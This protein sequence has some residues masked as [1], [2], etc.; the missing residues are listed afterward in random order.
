MKAHEPPHQIQKVRL[1]FEIERESEAVWFQNEMSRLFHAHLSKAIE[2]VLDEFDVPGYVIRLDSLDLDLGVVAVDH[3]DH[4]LPKLLEDALR[5]ALRD[6]LGTPTRKPP[7]VASTQAQVLP[8]ASAKI[9][10]LR[11]F[12][13]T[14]NA[15]TGYKVQHKSMEE[16][17]Q[18]VAEEAADEVKSMLLEAFGQNPIVLTRIANQFHGRSFE[19]IYKMFV[20]AYQAFLISQEKETVALLVRHENQGLTFVQREVR[21][22][23]LGY[24]LNLGT[25]QFEMPGF[26]EALRSQMETALGPGTRAAL[27]SEESSDPLESSSGRRL[28]ASVKALQN[29]LRSKSNPTGKSELLAAWEKL[30]LEDPKRLAAII[31]ANQGS[32][33]Q[34]Q[35]LMELLPDVSTADFLVRV[36]PS[37]AP[38]LSLVLAEVVSIF[39]AY[40]APKSGIQ[41]VRSLTLAQLVMYA[42]EVSTK[43]QSFSV[44]E[45][46]KR[47]GQ[48]VV[49]RPDIPEPLKKALQTNELPSLAEVVRMDPTQSMQPAKQ[50]ERETVTETAPETIQSRFEPAGAQDLDLMELELQD[51]EIKRRSEEKSRL[52]QQDFQ[53]KSEEEASLEKLQ[54][55]VQRQSDDAQKPKISEE[56]SAGA[57]KLKEK[58]LPPPT[59]ETIGGEEKAAT[60][61]GLEEVE[62]PQQKISRPTEVPVS[63][64]DEVAHY[65]ETISGRVAYLTHY[66]KHGTE[67]WWAGSPD[68]SRV[69]LYFSALLAVGFEPLKEAFVRLA[70]SSLPAQLD[71]AVAR[72]HRLVGK[73]LIV[74]FISKLL[75]DAGGLSAL[76]SE[77]M[78]GF[79]DTHGNELSL[80]VYISHPKDLRLHHSLK[81]ALEYQNS[82]PS[83]QTMVRYVLK[84]FS[85][86]TGKSVFD[87]GRDMV[88]WL[89]ERIGK[90]DRRYIVL[91]TILSTSALDLKIPEPVQLQPAP[92]EI[93]FRIWDRGGE[94]NAIAKEAAETSKET[95]TI[96]DREIDSQ[97]SKDTPP[98][99]LIAPGGKDE[100]EASEPMDEAAERGSE[101]DES[102]TSPLPE[103]LLWLESPS[104]GVKVLKYFL[105]TGAIPGDYP[106]PVTKPQLEE[107]IGYLLEAE[108]ASLAAMLKKVMSDR[109]IRLRFWRELPAWY[110][111]ILLVLMPEMGVALLPFVQ[112]MAEL[113]AFTSSPV[114]KSMVMEHALAY[115]L[116]VKAAIFSPL[117]YI[118]SLV[119]YA[120]KQGSLDARAVV[121]YFETR[122]EQ[123]NLPTKF[124]L[125][126][127]FRTIRSTYTPPRVADSGA[128]T[129]KPAPFR[130]LQDEYFVSNAGVVLLWPFFGQLFGFMKLLKPDK[131]EFVDELSQAK[132]AHVIQY[133]FSQEINV[134]EENMVLNKV[135]VGMSP[136]DQLMEIDPLTQ[137]EM[138]LVAELLGVAAE[139]SG[140]VKGPHGDALRET[141]MDREGRLKKEKEG[142]S[143]KVQ[144]KAYDLLLGRLQWGLNPVRMPWLKLKFQIEWR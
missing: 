113:S 16:L 68:L 117:D 112:T 62:I 59:K 91:K 127:V 101:R 103:A 78:D 88:A 136:E 14:G 67:P 111:R 4:K 24:I 28:E 6:K 86:A 45:A 57:E 42:S 71:E 141:F 3:M 94:A 144:S 20:P 12:L 108:P 30:S 82:S 8:L 106:I 21:K 70:A 128:S 116:R 18:S 85:F 96:K 98:S 125:Q 110:D 46:V 122:L 134:P 15:T 61:S 19:L 93:K 109:S 56:D 60:S 90:G 27:E 81:F 118:R 65:L 49:R 132:A 34:L 143:L 119:Q 63:D 80:P 10:M 138:D 140:L 75:P 51:P 37:F 40:A 23:I 95:P 52:N 50:E 77:V 66:A 7:T 142:W 22:A 31:R 69:E 47:V 25:K 58:A 44:S 26:K 73:R 89:D 53:F 54:E 74:E 11:A 39:Q 1:E 79:L 84:S 87:L 13:L 92:A 133:L 9:D 48:A 107:M 17:F 139:R 97:D 100:S 121:N 41:D 124:A 126:Q 2:R 83:A 76:I 33:S 137:E 104:E 129:A 115:V 5:K 102:R 130:P 72:M 99:A 64:K 135:L 29:F 32:L 35:K 55:E 131:K 38:V 114:S 120:S 123:T 43:P 105:E 36:L